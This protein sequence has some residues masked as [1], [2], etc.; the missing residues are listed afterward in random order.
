MKVAI[1]A[2]V[3]KDEEKGSQ[4]Y[5]DPENQLFALRK[6]AKEKNYEIVKEYIDRAS[7][8]DS[9]RPA[10]RKMMSESTLLGFNAILIWKMDRFSREPQFV[11]LAYIQKLR[12]QGIGIISMTESFINTCDENPMADFLLTIWTWFSDYERRKISERTKLGIARKKAEGTWKGGRRKG[13]KD[14][15]PR[16]KIGYFQRHERERQKRKM[17]ELAKQMGGRR[18]TKNFIKASMIFDQ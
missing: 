3:S 6:F 17:Q 8:A 10:F 4:R 15:K 12:Q 5:Q 14:K 11:Q 7:G 2:R 1:Y 9:S 18:T 13:A 16:R